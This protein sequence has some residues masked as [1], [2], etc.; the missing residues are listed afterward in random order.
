MERV[1]ED[2]QFELSFPVQPL[3]FNNDREVSA[4]PDSDIEV[5]IHAPAPYP[6]KQTAETDEAGDA[7]ESEPVKESKM[8]NKQRRAAAAIA[9]RTHICAENTLWIG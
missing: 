9:P 8:N 2:H 6:T 7:G 1:E 4:H 3:T 5:E